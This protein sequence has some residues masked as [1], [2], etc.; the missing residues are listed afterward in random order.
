MILK[1]Y[2][3]ISKILQLNL[4]ILVQVT[5]GSSLDICVINVFG[6]V[7]LFHTL[8]DIW[9]ADIYL[10]HAWNDVKNLFHMNDF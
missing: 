5:T 7:D 3:L 8:T 9:A 4:L 2:K 6:H 1:H 10:K